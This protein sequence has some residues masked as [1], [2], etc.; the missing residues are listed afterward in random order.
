MPLPDKKFTFFYLNSCDTCLKI[1]KQL[2]KEKLELVNIKESPLNEYQ[3]QYLYNF[4]GSYEALFNFRAQKLKLLDKIDKP[5]REED[6]KK[7]LL[8]DYTYLRR[9]VIVVGEKIFIGNSPE[10]IEQLKKVLLTNL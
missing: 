2:P 4:A 3:L 5:S 9:P 6:F 8:E 1:L 10:N 7:Y